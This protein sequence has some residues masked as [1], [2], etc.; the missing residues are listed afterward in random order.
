[1]KMEKRDRWWKYGAGRRQR[2]ARGGA[3]VILKSQV[4]AHVDASSHTHGR[5]ACVKHTE[6][7]RDGRTPLLWIVEEKKTPDTHQCV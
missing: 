5:K 1:M 3:R 7:D 4:D 2:E 6:A